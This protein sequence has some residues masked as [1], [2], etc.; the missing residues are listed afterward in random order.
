VEV[1][2]RLNRSFA[3]LGGGPAKSFLANSGAEAVENAVKIARSHTR[4]QAVICFEH[5]FHGRTYMAMTLTSKAK[6]YKE[7]FAPFNPEVY[8]APFPYA[9]R[10]PTSSD[11]AVVARE[12]FEEFSR[13]ALSQISANQVAAVIFE[14]VLGEGGFIPIPP[15]FIRSVAEFC[16]QHGIVLIADEIRPVSGAPAPLFACEQLAVTPDLVIT[17][18]GWAEDFQ[19]PR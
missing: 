7:G 16:K 1:C 14:P 15:A 10:W 12:C 3:A 13:L 19:S 6:P 5:A 4:R 17:A 18:K 9:Y 2:R 8:R 11:P